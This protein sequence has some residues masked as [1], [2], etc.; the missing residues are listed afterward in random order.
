M[1]LES[2]QSSKV[3]IDLNNL[4]KKKIRSNR[5]P[6][7]LTR[8]RLFEKKPNHLKISDHIRSS[9]NIPIRSSSPPDQIARGGT[10]SDFDNHVRHRMCMS[11][12]DQQLSSVLAMSSNG[13][14]P[15]RFSRH[16]RNPTCTNEATNGRPLRQSM[17][18]QRSSSSDSIRLVQQRHL[19]HLQQQ[20]QMR[21]T[22]ERQPPL[23]P[24]RY[25]SDRLNRV[26]DS[27]DAHSPP[28][29]HSFDRMSPAWLAVDRYK[30]EL[31]LREY[32]RHFTRSL[33]NQTQ[34]YDWTSVAE[35]QERHR[36]HEIR[37]EEQ[38]RLRDSNSRHASLRRDPIAFE[39][40]RQS[41]LDEP[42]EMSGRS[43][44]PIRSACDQA[45][46]E[47]LAARCR[48]QSAAMNTVT[49]SNTIVQSQRARPYDRWLI[50]AN[51][52]EHYNSRPPTGAAIGAGGQLS[53]EE[54]SAV[55]V[56]SNQPHPA[57]CQ[58]STSKS[59]TSGLNGALHGR[60]TSNIDWSN[61]RLQNRSASP[62][63]IAQ[64]H[65]PYA[66][67]HHHS[68]ES[69]QQ[70]SH[71]NHHSSFT[72]N[73]L[74][75][76]NRHAQRLSTSL[77]AQPMPS[78]LSH[79]QAQSTSASSAH[80][81]ARSSEQS[82]HWEITGDA[83]VN[84]NLRR[85]SQTT[86]FATCSSAEMRTNRDS[87]AP[88]PAHDL[89]AEAHVVSSGSS[90][91]PRST[92]SSMPTAARAPSF[93]PVVASTSS[94][95]QPTSHR[96]SQAHHHRNRE[97]SG[98]LVQSSLPPDCGTSASDST[99][100]NEPI[101]LDHYT[102]QS[103]YQRSLQSNMAAANGDLRHRRRPHDLSWAL[104][105]NRVNSRRPG[106]VD[107]GPHSY[108]APLSRSQPASVAQ[109]PRPPS[110]NSTPYR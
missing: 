109:T 105:R 84:P 87:P 48:L 1:N 30:D 17:F 71:L 82:H 68:H 4:L 69:H 96:S 5:T 108:D 93:H 8:G 81:M 110:T 42:S 92:S 104:A 14:I 75:F 54:S 88:M 22:I 51:S 74:Q 102:T 50:R 6:I 18:A 91:R 65:S 25:S 3:C 44:G 77:S 85:S 45:Y 24:S 59:A 34:S 19:R 56:E 47:L 2:S 63:I 38:Q 29:D 66:H 23:V 76:S 73:D 11:Q 28:S 20:E 106:G 43:G 78:T 15:G 60:P 53:L 55:A 41:S 99:E 94:L 26:C 72:P 103:R 98:S 67:H 46:Q 27:T 52:A 100:L 101:S 70:H 62:V 49:T 80:Q 95:H 107:S 61:A 35:S 31:M 97:Q 86:A 12:S 58:I 16:S 57:N 37:A 89:D 10:T 36:L 90:R 79:S 64:D 13:S 21:R 9:A 40:Q 33:K 83:T 7:T 39:D 32:P